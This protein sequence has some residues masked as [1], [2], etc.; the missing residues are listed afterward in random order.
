MIIVDCFFGEG[1]FCLPPLLIPCFFPFSLTFSVVKNAQEAH[2][3]LAGGFR[4]IA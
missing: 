2:D 4:F 1:S 3:V